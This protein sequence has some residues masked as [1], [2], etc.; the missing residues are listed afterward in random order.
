[1]TDNEHYIKLVGLEQLVQG[2]EHKQE[3]VAGNSTAFLKAGERVDYVASDVS[4]IT[5]TAYK[6]AYAH[7]SG[8]RAGLVESLRHLRASGLEGITFTLV[9]KSIEEVAEV[10]NSISLY[11]ERIAILTTDV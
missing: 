2:P 8:R 4:Y 1:M 3:V 9:P 11:P 7:V 5:L 10:S 6:R